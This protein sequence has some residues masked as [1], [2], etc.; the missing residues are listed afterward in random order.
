[1]GD[2]MQRRELPLLQP[3]FARR[4]RRH[5]VL[6][7][8]EEVSAG[9]SSASPAPARVVAAGLV[10]RRRGPGRPGRVAAARGNLGWWWR[11]EDVAAAAAA[12]AAAPDGRGVAAA[13]GGGGG[14]AEVREEI[15]FHSEGNSSEYKREKW[16]VV[17]HNEHTVARLY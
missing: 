12:T 4:W 1:M 6:V 13:S 8:K 7:P 3:S 15:V 17:I 2:G 14:E 10:L 11:S 16:T 9:S 5:P